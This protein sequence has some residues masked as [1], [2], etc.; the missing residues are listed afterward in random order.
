MLN[1]NYV[2]ID[3][4]LIHKYLVKKEDIN[5]IEEDTIFIVEIVKDFSDYKIENI[6]SKLVLSNGSERL[7]FKKVSGNISENNK[8]IYFLDKYED[9][10]SEIHDHKL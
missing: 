8:F 6:D 9:S 7:V 3:C 1:N 5:K 10:S 4:G 2:L